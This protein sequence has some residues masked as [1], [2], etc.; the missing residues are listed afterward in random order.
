MAGV[1]WDKNGTRRIH[2]HAP[3]GERKTIHW[4]SLPK[5]WLR[6]SKAKIEAL[7]SAVAANQPPDAETA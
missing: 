6:Q 7:V 2:F 3:D 4:A 5:S 1:F